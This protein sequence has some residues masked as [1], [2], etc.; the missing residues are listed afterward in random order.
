MYSYHQDDKNTEIAENG[1]IRRSL[2]QENPNAIQNFQSYNN[3]YQNDG[4]INRNS[5]VINLEQNPP[6]YWMFYLIIG[7]IQII[8]IIFLANFYYWDD[9]NKP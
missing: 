4:D 6:T 2:G 9:Y 1:A 5:I 7:I 3:L 8:F